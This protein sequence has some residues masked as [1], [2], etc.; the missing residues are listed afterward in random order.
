M[1]NYNETGS[2]KHR[3]HREHGN[4]LLLFINLLINYGR[5]LTA[6][7]YIYYLN[8]V[9]ECWLD[10]TSMFLYGRH[11]VSTHELIRVPVV[12]RMSIQTPWFMLNICFLS[13][14]L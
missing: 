1:F 9:F 8:S 11:Q 14:N 4:N 5:T 3:L 2:K 10:S 7:A 12:F 13:A 6:E